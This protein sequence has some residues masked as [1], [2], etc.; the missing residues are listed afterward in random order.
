MARG[1]STE[2][3]SSKSGLWGGGMLVCGASV[4]PS[5]AGDGAWVESTGHLL[6]GPRPGVPAPPELQWP[7]GSGRLLSGTRRLQAPARLLR[8]IA[9]TGTERVCSIG[10]GQ[11]LGLPLASSA[12]QPLPPDTVP[13]QRQL[14]FTYL[15]CVPVFLPHDG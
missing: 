11:G 4:W 12:L 1:Q 5:H 6:L 10:R 3:G 7:P 15:L 14:Q 8:L 9:V 13:P 2:K